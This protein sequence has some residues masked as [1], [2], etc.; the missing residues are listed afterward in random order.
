VN[1]TAPIKYYVTVKSNTNGCTKMDSVTVARNITAPAGVTAMNGGAIT[2]T[3]TST[4]ITA[5]STTPGVSY[6]WTGPN[7]F[8]SSSATATVTA[9]GT[10]SLVVVNTASGCSVSANTPVTK[11]TTPPVT[12]INPPTA[13]LSPLSFDILTARSVTSASYKWTLTSDDVNWAI[14]AGA[15]STTLTYMSG[16]EGSSGT[17]KL[18]VTDNTNG[19]SDSTQ[20]VLSV[21]VSTVTAIATPAIAEA[22][23]SS[24]SSI[25]P[26]IEYNAYPNPFTDKAY[27]TFKSPVTTKVTVEVFGYSGSPERI[28]FNDLARAGESY[29]LVFNPADLPSGI[30]YCVIRTNGKVY[31]TRLLLVR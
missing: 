6:A 1:G 3:K 20:L 25:E 23:S 11:N 27:I 19:C 12:V 24:I 31:T 7:G 2:C 13:A 30:H 28:L 22:S 18:K 21:P 4:S 17:F 15:T 29:K 10:Y 26:V 14:S 8:A 16:E 9:A 5:T